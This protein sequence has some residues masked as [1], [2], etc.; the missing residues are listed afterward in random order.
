MNEP[1]IPPTPFKDQLYCLYGSIL[2]TPDDPSI[3][4][5]NHYV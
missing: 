2:G 5:L 1:E 4:A 3:R